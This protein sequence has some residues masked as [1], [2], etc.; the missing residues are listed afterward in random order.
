M[1]VE[2]QPEAAVETPAPAPVA[3]TAVPVAVDAPV[4]PTGSALKVGDPID[5]NMVCWAN[6]AENVRA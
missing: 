6:L 3:D 4:G 1:T 5:I 2:S